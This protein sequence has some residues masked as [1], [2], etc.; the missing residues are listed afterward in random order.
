MTSSMALVADGLIGLAGAGTTTALGTAALRRPR[1]YLPGSHATRAERRSGPLAPLRYGYASLELAVRLGEAGDLL[2][3]GGDRIGPRV[4]D[5]L[6]E[7]V[8]CG[9]GRVY[10]NQ[11]E[12]LIVLV[13]LLEAGPGRLDLAYQLLDERLRDYPGLFTRYHAGAVTLGPV[14]LLLTGSSCPRH[15]L[16]AQSD[17]YAFCDG[18]FGDLGAWAAPPTLVPLVSE[19]WAW[20]FG[21]DGREELSGEER[22]LLRGLVR[23]AHTDGRGVRVFGIPERP[24]RVRQRFWRELAAARVDLIGSRNLIALRRFLR[25]RN[26]GRPGDRVR[27]VVDRLRM[28]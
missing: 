24:R 4:L 10:P 23:S 7:R 25:T 20:R 2:V 5:P 8:R 28:W 17:R 3:D 27:N 21:W 15:L 14:T 9:G 13:E 26:T 19:H 18:T 22:Y 11:T 12:P 6:A 16:A 1:A